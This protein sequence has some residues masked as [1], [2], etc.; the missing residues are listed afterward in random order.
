MSRTLSEAPSRV[1]RGSTARAPRGRVALGVGIA[2]VALLLALALGLAVGTR[3]VDLGQAIAAVVSPDLSQ[4]DQV[5]VRD[6]RL[7]RTL[8]GLLVGLALGTAGTLMQG[9]T[10]NPI[11][12]PGLFGINAGAAFAAVIE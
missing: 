12:D 10:R 1:L 9:I 11:A 4:N 3:T 2:F 8:T 7:P 6:I 5:V